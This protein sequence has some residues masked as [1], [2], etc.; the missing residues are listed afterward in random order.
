MAEDIIAG[1]RW[2]AR[3]VS[4][5]RCAD[6]WSEC[7]AHMRATLPA[8]LDFAMHEGVDGKLYAD[9]I[10]AEATAAAASR[11][12][13]FDPPKEDQVAA[14]EAAM[15]CRLYRGWP[16]CETEDVQRVFAMADGAVPDGVAEDDASPALSPRGEARL[17][18]LYFQWFSDWPRHRARPYIDFHCRHL[19]LGEVGAALAHVQLIDRAVEDGVDAHVFF[20]DDARPLPDAVQKLLAEVAALERS[21]FAWD[22]I[23]LRASLYSQTPE[24]PLADE[25]VAGSCLFRA[26]HRKV[27]DAY[28]LSRRGLARI[29][30]S[31]YRH[32]L[33]AFDD[34]LPSLHSEH[35]R[36]DVMR[37]PCVRA[38]RCDDEG[39]FVGL[40]FG[41]DVL[42]EV[43]RTGSETNMSPCVIGDHG[44]YG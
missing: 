2:R 27:T 33:F 14:V 29:A 30:A 40:S 31:G 18:D 23:Y 42:S 16:V 24:Q 36:R 9:L 38:A 44:T 5:R 26:R 17:W 34:F 12:E 37:L 8:W 28:C 13:A 11:D 7:E 6:R 21:G 25:A 32:C 35:P 39:G 20:E 1:W 3:A 41:E 4:L 22:L 15:G 43:A 10:D 19:T